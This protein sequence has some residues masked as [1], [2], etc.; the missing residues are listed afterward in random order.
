[1]STSGCLFRAGKLIEKALQPSS[2]RSPAPLQAPLFDEGRL[3]MTSGPTR[4]ALVGAALRLPLLAAAMSFG[5]PLTA[6]AGS[7]PRL[8]PP[9]PFDFERLKAMA[10]D[11]ASA[12]CACEPP[13]YA[14]ILQKIDYDATT[15]I[16]YRWAAALWA[17]SPD[18]YPVKMFH[19]HRYSK[20]PVRIFQ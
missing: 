12:P 2:S 20:E 19:L 4:R 7:L 13:R 15:K 5:A 11:A 9:Q 3:M 10:R 6:T 17:D 1:Q 14:D 18:A 8:R 16:I